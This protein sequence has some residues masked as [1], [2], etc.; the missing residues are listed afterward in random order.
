[1]SWWACRRPRQ[2]PR[3]LVPTCAEL[4]S[5]NLRDDINDARFTIVTMLLGRAEVVFRLHLETSNFIEGRGA[6]RMYVRM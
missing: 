6:N 1:M 5:L 3:R 2:R 4:S